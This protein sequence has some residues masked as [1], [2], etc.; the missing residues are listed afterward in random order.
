[1]TSPEC[2]A[3]PDP[4]LCLSPEDL[5]RLAG[6]RPTLWLCLGEGYSREEWKQ[7]LL[8]RGW[9]VLGDTLTGIGPL[10][11]R[12]LGVPVDRLLSASARQE[13]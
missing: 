7:L 2:P 8:N 12:I 13:V 11:A 5:S 4:P 9:G 6:L 3:L 1:M 10:A